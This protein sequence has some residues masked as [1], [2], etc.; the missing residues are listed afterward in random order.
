M[1][2]KFDPTTIKLNSIH[3]M[4]NPDK[5]F[6]EK[7]SRNR[8]LGNLPHP[9]TLCLLGCKNRGKSNTL[10]NIFLQHQ[11]SNKPFQ[12][13]IIVGPTNG[14]PEY[15]AMEPTAVLTDIPDLSMFDK[16]IKTL[17]IFDDHDLTK[18]S[19]I[20]K[21]NL[22][23]LFRC[24]T[25]VGLSLGIAYQSFFDVPIIVRNTATQFVLWKMHD[26]IQTSAIAKKVGLNKNQ[27]HYLIDTYLTDH[28]D[29]IMVDLSKDT[30]AYLRK[31]IFEKLE[32]PDIN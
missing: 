7:W 3:V 1:S 2:K 17:L 22:S 31:N 11:I 12:R 15:A 21:R 30:P 29:F 18:L 16:N 4:K 19:P 23:E 10:V 5:G 27:L 24:N 32:V 28:Y 9:F 25:H 8:S 14:A 13:L 20:Q 26:K 6:H